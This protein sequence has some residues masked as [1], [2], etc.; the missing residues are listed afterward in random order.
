[1]KLIDRRQFLELGLAAGATVAVAGVVDAVLQHSSGSSS[2]AP[3]SDPGF[4]PGS[5]APTMPVGHLRP[6]A[7]AD[8]RLLV[9]DMAGGNDGLSMV[10]PIGNPLYYA[11][12]PRTSLP[13]AQI[14]P[15]SAAVGLHP[16]LVKLHARGA[17]IIQ[18]VGVPQPDLS[19][20]EMLRR[21]WAG[22]MDANSETLTGFLGRLCDTIGD[23]TATA[24]GV[25]LGYGPT[26]ALISAKAVTLSMDPYSNGAF[27]TP[28]VL[29]AH[30]AWLAG[31]KNMAEYA[32][33]ETV[34]FCSARKG[35]AYA[36]RF[37]QLAANFPPADPAY[38]AT[39]LGTQLAL[40]A[41]MLTENNGI[42]IVHVPVLGDFDTHDDH[43][44]RHAA[45]MAE[46]DAALDAFL[47]DL[48]QRGIADRV[49]V[50]TTSEFGRRL[51][52]NASNGLDHGAASF[53]TFVGPVVNGLYGQYPSLATLDPNDNLV[54]QV[55]MSDYYATIAEAWFGV[56][57]SEVLAGSATPIS[58]LIAG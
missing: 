8:R 53:A 19:H 39:E 15:V 29:D 52:D 44:V 10:P 50:A 12:R 4:G 20:F 35:A 36:L 45:L 28:V 14:L 46:L 42:R 26:P 56:P 37:S 27:P 58:G 43:L 40:A 7:L 49:L 1:M 30:T 3:S 51:P 48:G 34:P 32:P 25:S 5:P 54:V 18:G 31:W 11:A 57:A 55:P 33:T 38:P 22:Q 2:G 24:V 21:W 41:R 16:N 6:A 47:V 9:L 23:P 17:A 13:A